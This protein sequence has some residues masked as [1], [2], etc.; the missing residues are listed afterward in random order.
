MASRATALTA[1][2]LALA[3]A[4]NPQAPS[5][6]AATAGEK[7]FQAGKFAE[8]RAEFSRAVAAN[9]EDHPAA[10][11]LGHLALLENRFPEA[12]KWLK[13]AEALQPEHKPTRGLL[14][15]LYYR[16]DD[17]AQ[18]APFFRAADREVIALKLESLQG[19]TPYQVS[20][21]DFDVR[22]KWVQTDPLPVV[23]ASVNGGALAN[24]II[25]TGGPEIILGTEFAKAAGVPEFGG[26]A[27]QLAGGRATVGHGRVDRFTIGGLEVR[28]VPVQMLDARVWTSG[29]PGLK[30]DGVIGS[31][32]LY[33]FLSTL[34]YVKGE[35]RLQ[36]RSK[37]HLK[38]LEANVK[39]GE[40]IAVPFWLAGDHFMLAWG[41]INQSAPMLWFV[42][43]G[44]AGGGFIGSSATLKEAGIDS[45]LPQD[46]TGAVVTGANRFNVAEL[47]LGDAVERNISGL[48]GNLSQIGSIRIGGL[49]S[50]QFFKRY[51]ITLDFTKMRIFLRR[52]E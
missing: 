28:N 4:A 51:A 36:P 38:G 37:K 40:T 31:V 41:R 12:E 17:F 32:F 50:H 25:D 30:V 21:R 11:R 2:I 45:A 6:P 20:K 1:A 43:T 47:A 33:H 13:H 14:A 9:T 3:T 39:K 16:Q 10:L 23:Q 46:S 27:G 42:D 44:L 49:I 34:D 22:V 24:F 7:L 15:E 48:Q 29:A 8:A 26:T 5:T 52:Q 35:L 19:T 18:A